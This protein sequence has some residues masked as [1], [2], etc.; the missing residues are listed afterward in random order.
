VSLTLTIVCDR[1]GERIDTKLAL[2]HWCR[3]LTEPEAE[4][5]VDKFLDDLGARSGFK[6]TLELRK[7]IRV[8]WLVL[9]RQTFQ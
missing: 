9:V 2:Q 1:C 6:L 7:M 3:R 5:L 4:A 8:D